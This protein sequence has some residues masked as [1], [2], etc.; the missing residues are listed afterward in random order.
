MLALLGACCI[1]IVPA[2]AVETSLVAS[3]WWV[4]A[5]PS[6]SASMPAEP[7][8]PTRAGPIRR[9]EADPGDTDDPRRREAAR[10]FA[11]GEAAF[12]RE[13]YVDA[14]E[15]FGRAHALVPHRWTLYNH[16][17]SLRNA[18]DPVAAWRAFGELESIA[19]TDE[20]RA[21]AARE[22]AALR[23]RIAFAELR[24]PADSVVCIDRDRVQLG[25]AGHAEWIGTPGRH[26]LATHAGARPFDTAAGSIT[27]LE[28]VAPKRRAPPGRGWL[29]AA[30]VGSAGGVAGASAAAALTDE[31]DARIA[32]SVGASLAG[33]ALIASIV[34]L[35]VVEREAK[36]RRPPPLP[37][38]LARDH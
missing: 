23:E 13:D 19:T 24:G 29:V 38:E 36:R 18:G 28:V 5:P 34:G 21:E 10:A 15:R 3:P 37:C 31:R 7:P 30:I 32:A 9:P 17:V 27:R 11:D 12:E 35:A 14:A 25:R 33:T 16:A 8:A 6:E 26:E 2:R 20:E 22:R 4:A 1:A